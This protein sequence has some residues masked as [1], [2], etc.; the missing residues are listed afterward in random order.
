MPAEAWP[1]FH[2]RPSTA[3]TLLSPSASIR[4]TPTTF[5]NEPESAPT[6]SFEKSSFNGSA[7]A[8]PI[9]HAANAAPESAIALIVMVWLLLTTLGPYATAFVDAAD[10]IIG[11]N[12]KSATQA[13]MSRH[14]SE[15]LNETRRTTRRRRSC[16]RGAR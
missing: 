5:T 13:S 11:V 6:L 7:A 9:R 16:R 12:T 1:S 8:T 2:C 4:Q 15:L 14:L 3:S 10:R